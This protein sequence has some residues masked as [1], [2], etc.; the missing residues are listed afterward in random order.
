MGAKNLGQVSALVISTIQPVNRY[1]IWFDLSNNNLKYYNFSTLVWESFLTT[2]SIGQI[3]LDALDS[4]GYLIDKIDSSLTISGG[5]LKVAVPVTSAEKAKWNGQTTTYFVPNISGLSS[6]S[7]NTGDRAVVADDGDGKRAGY[8]WSGTQWL[9][10]FDP[11]WEN[12]N[13]LWAN[14]SDAAQ[15][16]IS[17]IWGNNARTPNKNV[18][19]DASGKLKAV[20]QNTAFNKNFGKDPGTIPDIASQ[21]G[22]NQILVTDAN[23]KLK[24]SD[25]NPQQLAINYVAVGS[26]DMSTEMYHETSVFSLPEYFRIIGYTVIINNDLNDR[27][28]SFAG[29]FNDLGF[30]SNGFA[31]MS[32][33]SGTEDWKIIMKRPDSSIWDSSGYQSIAINRG[34]IV[35]FSRL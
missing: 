1:V 5:Q 19:T 10:D 8:Y 9:K 34:Y 28:D 7:P 12:I 20:D 18:E 2:A 25:M 17:V 16:V 24:T 3:K 32:K 35:L 29:S 30:V 15:G 31:T 13:L 27:K 11:D 23:G 22:A 26:W 21:L 14:I 4:L 33:V 6:L